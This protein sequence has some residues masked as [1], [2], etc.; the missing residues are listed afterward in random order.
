MSLEHRD[1]LARDPLP[2]T[3]APSSMTLGGLVK[4]LTLVED[5]WFE[6]FLLAA[7]PHEPWASVDCTATPDWEWESALDDD[8]ADLVSRW[9]EAVERSRRSARDA[10][11]AGGLG[12]RAATSWSDGRAPNLRWIVTHMIEEYARHNGHADLLRE[13][14]DGKVGE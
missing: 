10:F 1:E 2:L 9:Q 3:P 6:R 12:R 13:A 7:P 14:V 4:H 11:E 8:P 5:D